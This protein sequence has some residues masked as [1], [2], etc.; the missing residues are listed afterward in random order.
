MFK[1]WGYQ[2]L[3]ECSYVFYKAHNN[4]ML[5]VLKLVFYLLQ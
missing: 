3:L 5:I 4:I 2:H 1:D